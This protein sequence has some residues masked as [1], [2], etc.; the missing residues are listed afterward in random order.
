[1][2]IKDKRIYLFLASIVLASGM[3]L[4][5][6]L[7][8]SANA[9]RRGNIGFKTDICTWSPDRVPGIADFR[10]ACIAHDRCYFNARRNRQATK[11]SFRECDRRF[12]ANMRRACRQQHRSRVRRVPCYDLATRYYVAVRS[13]TE[14]GRRRR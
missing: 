5:A 6:V 7:P 13:L 1:M 14:S 11:E 8:M 10:E 3:A 9:Q 4:E 12:L 2:N